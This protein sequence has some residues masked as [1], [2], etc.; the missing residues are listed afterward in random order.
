GLADEALDLL[1]DEAERALI[2]VDARADEPLR[3]VQLDPSMPAGVATLRLAIAELADAYPGAQF[4]LESVGDRLRNVGAAAATAELEHRPHL[5]HLVRLSLEALFR[6][7][8]TPEAYETERK[9]EEF[10][11][12]DSL[13]LI[14][15]Y[16]TYR[17]ILGL[18]R[19]QLS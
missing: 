5:L 15:N 12:E 14:E 8:P 10:F 18:L 19:R 4:E 7:Y 17:Q 1:L 16:E 6:M 11:E 13:S 9:E 2:D 3:R